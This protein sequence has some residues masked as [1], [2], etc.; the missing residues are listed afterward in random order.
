[1]KYK[2]NVKRDVDVYDD[3]LMLHLYWGWKFSDEVLQPTHVR[4]FDTMKEVRHEIKNL[5]IPCDCKECIE[6]LARDLASK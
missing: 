1:M 2:L 4:G 5:V 3:A 6:G